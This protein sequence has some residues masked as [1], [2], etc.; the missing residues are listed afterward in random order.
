MLR[1][2]S[3]PKGTLPLTDDQEEVAYTA[4]Y[5]EALRGADSTYV[6]LDPDSV[7]LAVIRR[8]R[9]VPRVTEDDPQFWE[10]RYWVNAGALD[11]WEALGERG[12]TGSALREMQK[13]GR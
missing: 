9:G 1:S 12:P 13:R 3:S 5:E 8:G 10:W 6:A 2:K 4:G 7:F 11:A